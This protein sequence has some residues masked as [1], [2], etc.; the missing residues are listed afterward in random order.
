MF[1]LLLGCYY[2]SILGNNRYWGRGGRGIIGKTFIST[3][4]ERTIGKN[5]S[6]MY[7]YLVSTVS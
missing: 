1:C 3:V 5:L 2:W 7:H 4:L 6:I